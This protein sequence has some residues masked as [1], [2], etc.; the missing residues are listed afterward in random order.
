MA[1]DRFRGTPPGPDEVLRPG[2][3]R[4]EMPNPQRLGQFIDTCADLVRRGQTPQGTEELPIVLERIEPS[5]GLFEELNLNLVF[6]KSVDGFTMDFGGPYRNA[7]NQDWNPNELIQFE[8]QLASQYRNEHV[9]LTNVEGERIITISNPLYGITFT[10]FIGLA[11]ERREINLRSEGNVTFLNVHREEEI[12][13]FF[14]MTAHEINVDDSYD[15]HAPISLP[16]SNPELFVQRMG[17]WKQ[18][19]ERVVNTAANDKKVPQTATLYLPNPKLV[20]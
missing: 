12:P 15:L 9:S 2:Q 10:A 8:H 14:F 6:N 20:S 4:V 17:A 19:M 16:K 3:F 5:G 1:R 7:R 13:P 11:I 18:A